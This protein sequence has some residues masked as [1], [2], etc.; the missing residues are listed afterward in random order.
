MILIQAKIFSRLFL[1]FIVFT[2]QSCGRLF[3][4][5]IF[6]SPKDSRIITSDI[7]NFYR[8][9]DL[10][11]NEPEN[12]DK[13][14]QQEYFGK[15]SKGLKDFYK[16]KIRSTE[17]FSDFVM[18][19]QDYY[20]SIRNDIININDLENRIY[21]NFAEFEKL[22]PQAKYPDVYF[23]VGSYR[24]N[25][26]I[27]RNGLLIGTEILAKTPQSDTAN[28]NKNILRISMPRDHIPVTVS[29][30][31][32]HFNQDNMKKGN[33][34]LWKSIRE[35]SAE[36]IAEIISGKTDADYKEF[37]GREIKIWQDFQK[38]KH[39]SI[40]SS[41]QQESESRPRNAGYW[42]GYIICKA[43]YEQVKNKETAIRDILHIADY[44][45]FYRK[46]KVDQYIAERFVP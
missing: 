29:H 1:I 30:E 24:S 18:K 36:F 4:A 22:Y 27:S 39:K 10:A 26:T 5:K 14:F 7:I 6:E 16:S 25:G 45:E 20:Q 19:Y 35:G 34:L 43:Y 11:V 23:V 32:V 42:A 15:G 37:Q 13:I 33:T 38:D 12:S 21:Y 44:E 17:Q 28:W 41:W 40:W 46:S 2:L 9:F 31:L 8:A 3:S